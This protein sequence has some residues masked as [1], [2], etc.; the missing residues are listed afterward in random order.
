[1]QLYIGNK[2]FK[3]SIGNKHYKIR[4]DILVEAMKY[5]GLIDTGSKTLNDVPEHLKA[6][7]EA[8]IK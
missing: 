4:N 5:A 8:L 7:V 2:K 6:L 1:M 3:L